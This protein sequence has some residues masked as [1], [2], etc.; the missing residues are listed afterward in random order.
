MTN[1]CTMNCLFIFAAAFLGW[2]QQSNAE[3]PAVGNCSF[4]EYYCTVREYETR[5]F[6]RLYEDPATDCGLQV[7][8]L[9]YHVL[10]QAEKCSTTGN[11]TK[12]LHAA[13]INEVQSLYCSGLDLE[14]PLMLSLSP[15]SN[16]HKEAVDHCISDFAT[17][18]SSH[19]AQSSLCR[20]RDKAKQCTIFAW[21]T[22]CNHSNVTDGILRKVIGSFN[23][24]CDGDKDPQAE[25]SDQCAKYPK[26]PDDGVSSPSEQPE[27]KSAA[28]ER[29]G[30]V[31][32]L[33][34]VVLFVTSNWY[35]NNLIT[36]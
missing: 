20:K 2:Q 7:W 31:P 33:F 8:I 6:K 16:K 18:F 5:L 17:T 13:D 9:N 35:P 27:S 23:P 12:S 1:F 11:H 15:C 4:M 10:K 3:L 24:F 26:P 25:E 29:N 14:R 30:V 34:Y 22:H 21:R 36:I 32:Y 19:F 28:G